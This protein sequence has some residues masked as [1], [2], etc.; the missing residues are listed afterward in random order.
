MLM[1]YFLC[2]CGPCRRVLVVKTKAFAFPSCT[3]GA[4]W[5]SCVFFLITMPLA[6]RNLLTIPYFVFVFLRQK[7]GFNLSVFSMTIRTDTVILCSRRLWIHGMIS[8]AT[9]LILEGRPV[10]RV[11]LLALNWSAILCKQTISRL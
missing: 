7:S 3:S 6:S 8:F 10:E 2:L 11:F 4:A 9:S 1:I 5:A